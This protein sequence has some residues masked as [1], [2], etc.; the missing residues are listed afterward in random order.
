MSQTF[1]AEVQYQ[2]W[3]GDA[4]AD[5]ADFVTIREYMK[6]RGLMKDG[7]FLVAI[8]GSNGEN[9]RNMAVTPMWVTA[10]LVPARDFDAAQKYLAQSNRVREVRFEMSVLEWAA[11]FK[12]FSVAMSWQGFDMA[13]RDYVADDE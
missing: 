3:S 8:R 13:G 10:L 5:D 2:D 1:R 6:E 7:D 9:T 12:R 11:A 4:A